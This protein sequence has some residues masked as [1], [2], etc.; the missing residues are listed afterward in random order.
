MADFTPVNSLEIRLRALLRDKHTPYWSF[1]TPLAA[2]RVWFITRHYP[3]LDGSDLVAPE[4]QNPD[5]CVFHGPDYSFVGLYTARCR[6]EEIFKQWDISR[7]DFTCVSTTG[8][9]ALRYLSGSE[10]DYICINAG[11]KDCQKTLDPDLVELLLERPEPRPGDRPAHNV[12]ID[13]DDDTARRL[14]P[15]KDFL[16]RQPTVR[17]AWIFFTQPDPPLPPGHRACELGL[18][19]QDPE[20]ESLLHQAGVIVKALTPVEMEWTPTVLMADDASLRNLAERQPPFYAA[21]G[22]LKEQ[23]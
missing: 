13:P 19:M 14:G 2:A 23:P 15:L 7:A 11:L 1:L 4:G 16:S 17:A 21:P 3:E 6:V 5:L 20:D 10:A 18:V 22:F 12:L 9:D 8:Y